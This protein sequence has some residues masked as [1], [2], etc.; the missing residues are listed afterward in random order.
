MREIEA[1]IITQKIKEGFISANLTLPENLVNCIKNS[2]KA[3]HSPLAKSVLSKLEENIRVAKEINVPICQDTGMAVVFASIGQ[4]VHISGGLFFDAVNLGV[5]EA[6]TD[7]DLRFSVVKDP[8][9]R[10][11]TNDN[12]PAIIHTQIVAG[13]KIEIICVPKGFGSENA[14]RIKMFEPSANENDIIDF[15]VETVEIAGGNPCRPVVVG[16]GIGG[17][18]E[19]SAI[20]AKRALTRE[21]GE[22]NPDAFYGDIEQRALKKINETDI[23]PAGF[24]GKTTA[25]SVN[26]ETYPTHIAGLPVAVNICCHVCRHKKIIITCSECE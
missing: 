9:K 8:L 23:G 13:D 15:I 10:G 4:D 12:T 21:I 25:F 26:I 17:D 3:E 11:N 14:S 22:A 1:K 7:G 16:V 24:G 2:A 6:Y 19:Y 20:M 5:R 18:F